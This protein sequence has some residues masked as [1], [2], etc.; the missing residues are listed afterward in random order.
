MPAAVIAHHSANVFRHR[1]QIT[2][3]ILDRLGR[4]L[5]LVLERVVDVR[6]VGL[7]MLGVMDLHRARIDVRLKRIVG[8]GKFR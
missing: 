1:V 6:D 3:Q 4:Q 2:D 8:V 7:V 5:R